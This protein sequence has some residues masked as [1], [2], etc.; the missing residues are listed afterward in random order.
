MRARTLAGLASRVLARRPPAPPAVGAFARAR[1]PRRLAFSEDIVASSAMAS[2]TA[3]AIGFSPDPS[4]AAP[5]FAR[6]SHASEVPADARLVYVSGQ[7]GVRVDGSCP[8][9]AAEQARNCLTNVR[10]ALEAAPGGPMGV[11]HLVR[12]NAFVTDPAY[13]KDYMR[14]RDACFRDVEFPN[15][16][17]ASTLMVVTAFARP[18]FKVEVEAVAASKEET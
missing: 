18:E 1:A 4:R 10:A 9:D 16:P 13:L 5:P 6:Y 8:P 12:L 11:Q 15:G 2:S 3:A 17:P 7:L 14:E